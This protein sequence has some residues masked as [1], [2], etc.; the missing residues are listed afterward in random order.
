MVLFFDIVVTREYEEIM[1]LKFDTDLSKELIQIMR[2]IIF[3]V[4]VE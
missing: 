2:N 4:F 3:W 1:N